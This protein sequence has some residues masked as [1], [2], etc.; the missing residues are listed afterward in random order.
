MRAK[1]SKFSRS[2]LRENLGWT[3]VGGDEVDE[4]DTIGATEIVAQGGRD[5]HW[6]R[7]ARTNRSYE[8]NMNMICRKDI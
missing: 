7:A 4:V 1:F 6:E 3:P 2:A 8:H 5:Q